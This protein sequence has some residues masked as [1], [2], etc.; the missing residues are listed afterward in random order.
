VILPAL[1]GEVGTNAPGICLVRK[2]GI[3]AT[4]GPKA[5]PLVKPSRAPL[6]VNFVAGRGVP[7]RSDFVVRAPLAKIKPASPRGGAL[8]DS[9]VSTYDYRVAFSARSLRG[10]PAVDRR[11]DRAGVAA[12]EE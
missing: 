10:R 1:S 6:F 3:R 11:T 7:H 4:I 2:D 5:R 8:G 9:L 12:S